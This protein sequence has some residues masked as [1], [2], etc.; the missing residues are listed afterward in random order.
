M[1]SRLRVT[2][3]RAWAVRATLEKSKLLALAHDEGLT[4]YQIGRKEPTVSF[5]NSKV[6][7]T[8]NLEAFTVNLKAIDLEEYPR[9][10]VPYDLAGKEAGSTD[11]YALHVKHSGNGNLLALYNTHEFCVLKTQ[12]FKNI[13]FG[14]GTGL[15]WSTNNEFAVFEQNVIRVFRNLEL[16]L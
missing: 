1:E 13:K 11:I 9:S 14:Q 5:H 8:K 2:D 10:G 3:N 6:L 12:A 16:A 15:A 4:F 7:Y